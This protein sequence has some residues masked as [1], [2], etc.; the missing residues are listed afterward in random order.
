MS[1]DFPNIDKKMAVFSALSMDTTYDI[2]WFQGRVHAVLSMVYG[3][4]RNMDGIWKKYGW[5]LPFVDNAI[6]EEQ[7]MGWPSDHPKEDSS[8]ATLLPCSV[9]HRSFSSSPPQASCSP[10]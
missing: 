1:I 4:G 2:G 10:G 9:K 5:S 7:K 8:S 6:D 3:Y